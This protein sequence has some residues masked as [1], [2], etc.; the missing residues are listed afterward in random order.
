MIFYVVELLEDWNVDVP[1][2]KSDRKIYGRCLVIGPPSSDPAGEI[3][4]RTKMGRK[5]A[6]KN[7][8]PREKIPSYFP[9]VPLG[10]E[11]GYMVCC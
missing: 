8:V 11:L 9:G 6:E 3:T 1:S 7:K 4:G 2:R 5:E 10:H